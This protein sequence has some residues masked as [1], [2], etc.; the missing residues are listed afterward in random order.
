MKK[1]T[2]QNEMAMI[3]EKFRLFQ[4]NQRNVQTMQKSRQQV[5]RNEGKKKRISIQGHPQNMM[6][7]IVGPLGTLIRPGKDL[8]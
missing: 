5:A 7:D 2:N 3:K 8:K 1:A 6:I 4:M